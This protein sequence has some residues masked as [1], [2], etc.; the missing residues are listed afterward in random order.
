M[1]EFPKQYTY[2]NTNLNLALYINRITLIIL[3]EYCCLYSPHA[4]YIL[5]T[6]LY[7]C[8]RLNRKY[9][10]ATTPLNHLHTSVLTTVYVY[11]S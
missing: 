9:D 3:Q 1:T 5:L 2:T 10:K 11:Q 6:A 7:I 4:C 8:K